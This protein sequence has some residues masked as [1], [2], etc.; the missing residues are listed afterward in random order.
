MALL[1]TLAL[2]V[3]FVSS[4]GAGLPNSVLLQD[5]IVRALLALLALL[6]LFYVADQRRRL[7]AQ[8]ARATQETEWAREQLAKTVQWLTFSHQAASILAARGIEDGLMGVLTGAAN[9]YHADAAAVVGDDLD[10]VFASDNVS[11]EEARRALMHIAITSAGKSEPL[12]IESLGIETGQ[13][14]AV[15]LRVRD[16]L[17]FVL[18]MWNKNTGFER[19]QLESLGLMGRMIE[20]AIER[21][22]LLQQAQ[23]E[24]EGTLSVLQYLVSDRRP[25]YSDH[26][27]RVSGLAS[28]LGQRLGM[29]V[30]ERKSLRLAGLIHD[31]GIM[32]LPRDFPSATEPL[33]LEQHLLMQQH[34]RVGAE[35][36]AAAHF[37]QGVQQAVETHHERMDGS[38]YPNNVRG[39]AIPITGRILAVAEVFDSMTNRGYHGSA[40]NIADA[41]D[42]LRSKAGV[43]YDEDV[44]NALLAEL[45]QRPPAMNAVGMIS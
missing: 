14:I 13:A 38:G 33:S 43:L 16:E 27:M 36:A 30:Q 22:D 2:L 45:K 19:G 23:T 8:V 35:I 24:L 9:L 1:A 26:A 39:S 10:S 5:N 3:F 37:S 6:V 44:V 40:L 20:L 18:C 42:E 29:T 21:E 31:V 7:R 11:Q 34:P 32:S 28:A 25:D 15:P 17:R 12:L 41:A 4:T